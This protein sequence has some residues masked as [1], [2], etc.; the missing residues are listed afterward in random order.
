[1][2]ANN[3]KLYKLLKNDLQM[4]DTKAGEFV[5]VLDAV[6]QSDIKESAMEYKS[7]IK[8]D[9]AEIDKKFTEIDKKFMEV[10]KRF[11]EVDKRFNEV[12]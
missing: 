5:D 9:L 1:M 10:D 8:D 3:I 7:I 2:N 12:G 6:I 4:P 11:I